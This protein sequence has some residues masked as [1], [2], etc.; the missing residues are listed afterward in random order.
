[1]R[2]WC[3]S[4]GRIAVAI[5]IVYTSILSKILQDIDYLSRMFSVVQQQLRGYVVALQE[6]LLHVTATLTLVTFV[7]PLTDA[8]KTLIFPSCMR[9]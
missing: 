5:R 7:D 3:I 4:A 8:N 9:S 1:M 2:E 6:V